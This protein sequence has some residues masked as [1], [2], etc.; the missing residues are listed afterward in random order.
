MEAASS[1]SDE[2]SPS[3]TANRQFW[4]R[5]IATTRFSHPDQPPPSH[6]SNNWVRLALPVGT[7]TLYREKGPQGPSSR[8]GMTLRLRGEAGRTA[9]DALCAEL[10][11]LNDEIGMPLNAL[12]NDSEEIG[13]VWPEPL[14]TTD[15]DKQLA[16][17]AQTSDRL[18]TAFRPRL[19]AF[20]G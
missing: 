14:V 13:K 6:G 3:G 4:D 5:F 2:I 12:W 16:W 9:F 17:L 15:E 1:R 11:E 8:C 20:T 10:S 19:S 7:L 18:V